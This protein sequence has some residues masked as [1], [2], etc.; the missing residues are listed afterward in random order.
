MA[1]TVRVHGFKLA[2]SDTVH[3]DEHCSHLSSSDSRSVE[4]LGEIEVD[5]DRLCRRCTTPVV[6]VRIFGTRKA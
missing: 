2:Y 1:D 4:D 3:V 5:P 6:L